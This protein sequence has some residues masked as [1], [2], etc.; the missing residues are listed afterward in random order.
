MAFH[1]IFTDEAGKQKEV[2]SKT[3]SHCMWKETHE[4]M[5]EWYD[6]VLKKINKY[7]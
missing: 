2:D 7:K 4:Q 6:K 3:V 1:K 5:Q